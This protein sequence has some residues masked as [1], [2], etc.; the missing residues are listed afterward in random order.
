M[1]LGEEEDERPDT[2]LLDQATDHADGVV[3]TSLRLI[4]HKGV[5]AAADNRDGVAGILHA[6]HLDYP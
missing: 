4:Q 1:V 3:K 6:R 2:L 5:G